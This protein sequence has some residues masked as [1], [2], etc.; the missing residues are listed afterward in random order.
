MHNL[1]WTALIPPWLSST[2]LQG[3]LMTD[4]SLS[5]RFWNPWLD[6]NSGLQAEEAIGR[7]LFTLFPDLLARDKAQFYWRALAGEEVS[8]TQR[9]HGY[10]LPMPPPSD[11]PQFAYMQQRARIGP[12]LINNQVVGT[13]T[14]IDDLTERAAQHENLKQTIAQQEATLAIL[15]TLLA[16]API[17]F[18]FLDTECR[19]LKVNSRLA[20]FNGLSLEAHL[21]STARETSSNWSTLIER[22]YRQVLRT[23]EP[24]LDIAVSGERN[25]RP[26]EVAHWLASYYPVQTS[27]NRLLGVGVL[28]T[29]ATQRTRQEQSRLLLDTVSA[30]LATAFN[31]PEALH[32]VVSALAPGLGDVCI[33]EFMTPDRGIQRVVAAERLD[34][35][36]RLALPDAGDL[37]YLQAGIR[38]GEAY[39]LDNL[40]QVELPTDCEGPSLVR[41]REL[42]YSAAL[43]APLV[44]RDL[45]LGSLIVAIKGQAFDDEQLR[46]AVEVSRRC[47]LA[48]DNARLTWDLQAAVQRM[49]EAVRMRDAFI[50]IAAHELRTPLTTLLGRAQ[51]LQKWLTRTPE[52]D[53]R[54]RRTMQIVVEQAQ[55]LNKMITALLDVSRIQS[56]RFSIEVCPLDLS[57]LVRQVVEESRL[58]LTEHSLQ[59]EEYPE[60]LPIDGDPVRLEQVFQ[61]LLSNAVKYSPG[62]GQITVRVWRDESRACVAVTDTGIGIPVVAHEQLF[63]RFYRAE[64]AETYKISGM[65]IGLFVVKE[66][67]ELHGGSIW[68]SSTEGAGSTFTVCLPLH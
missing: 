41:L 51:M 35:E 49:D 11:Y 38:A 17:G 32:R 9:E 30:N 23:G 66:I 34:H 42:S 31:E 22:Y 63:N 67:V 20:E 36:V 44:A 54:N 26:G 21:G 65:G 59:L 53:E 45:R 68:V 50:S 14:M 12:V 4:A 47:A 7:P 48:L 13:I 28:V 57:V 52:I 39:K 3:V 16:Q 1:D 5:V 33:L 2:L 58:T 19:F 40:E 29:D 24:I 25:E 60:P 43:V 61:N 18:G 46:L 56:G 10:L 64:N 55:R 62:G 6:L 8:L 15:D 27:S 37:G